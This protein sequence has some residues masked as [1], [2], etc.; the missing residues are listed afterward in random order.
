M[1]HLKVAELFEHIQL[2]ESLVFLFVLPNV[3]ANSLF[4]STHRRDKIPSGPKALASEIFLAS[5]KRSCDV[6]GTFAFD[7]TNYL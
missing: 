1:R 6:D 3:F 2:F 5:A 7:V 4:V